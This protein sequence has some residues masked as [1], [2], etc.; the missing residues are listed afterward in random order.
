M[1][2]SLP[3]LHYRTFKPETAASL[4]AQGLPVMLARLFAARGITDVAEV[5]AGL[6][7]LLPVATLKGAA[8]MGALLAECITSR[9]RVLIVSDYDCDG[10]TAGSVLLQ[11]FRGAKVNHDFLVPDRLKH[12][13]GLTPGIVEEAAALP[14]RPDFI[15]TVDNGIS[16]THGVERAR[17]LGIQV[18]VTDHHLCGPT[19]PNA[20]LIVNPNQPGCMFESKSIAGCGVAWYVAKAFHQAMIERG[21][22]PGFDPESLLTYVALGTVADIVRLD[23]NNRI[24]VREGLNRIRNGDCSP[25]IQ[26]LAAIAGRDI[27]TLSCQDVGFGIGPRINAAGR[28]AHMSAGIECLTTTDA[29]TASELAQQLEAINAERRTLQKAMVEEAATLLST[30]QD[31]TLSSSHSVLVFNPAWHEGVVGIVAGRLKDER[32]LPTFVL[33]NAQDGSIKGSGRSVEG[34][35][36]KHALDEINVAHPGLLLKF[37]GHAMAAGITIDETR[38]NEFASAFAAVCQA[39]LTPEMMTPRLEHDGIFPERAFNEQTIHALD[40]EVWGAGF[41]APLFVDTFQVNR[42]Q[43]MGVDGAHLKFNIQKGEIACDVVAFFEGAREHLLPAD[44]CLSFTP[45]LNTFR[46]KVSLQLKAD[47]LL[48]VPS[49]ELEEELSSAASRRPRI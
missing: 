36:L 43:T 5:R 16:S 12:G 20:R 4:Y 23:H 3:T 17:E 21:I 10:A 31:S 38:L 9:A 15:I 40:L 19:L 8:E 34:F 37:G 26:A 32:H 46:G 13:Y 18:L 44:V 29:G 24:L 1:T 35:H 28:L 45:A 22:Q 33:T 2:T 41:P 14:D 6:D 27:T 25:G 47:K 42:S 48:N 7:Q 49:L 11:A 30:D 39:H